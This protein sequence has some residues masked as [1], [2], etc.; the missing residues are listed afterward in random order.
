[1]TETGHVASRS[2][3]A[4]QSINYKHAVICMK[5]KQKQ[6]CISVKRDETASKNALSKN[7]LVL[8]ITWMSSASLAIFAGKY[9]YLSH[10]FIII[11]IVIKYNKSIF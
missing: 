8:L 6:P 10:I 9:K 4:L 3:K 1:M 2:W 7:M 11:L 5:K